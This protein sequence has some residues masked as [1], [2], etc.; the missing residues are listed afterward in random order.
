[1]TDRAQ[2]FWACLLFWLGWLLCFPW[3]IG[4]F[5]IPARSRWARLA[6]WMSLVMLIAVSIFWIIFPI[7]YSSNHQ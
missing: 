6:G 4:M 2:D 3:A 1:M 5:C 7:V